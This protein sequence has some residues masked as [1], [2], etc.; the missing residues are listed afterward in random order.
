MFFFV[1]LGKMLCHD[2]KLTP[3]V[4]EYPAAAIKSL[5]KYRIWNDNLWFDF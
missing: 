3:V 5:K 1:Q 4:Q 2:L